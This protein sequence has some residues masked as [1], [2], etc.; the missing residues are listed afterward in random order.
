MPAPSIPPE[1]HNL[2][3]MFAHE[4]ETPLTAIKGYAQLLQRGRVE[5]RDEIASCSGIIVQQANRVIRTMQDTVLAVRI[6][7][8]L[9]PLVPT[10]L[11]VGAVISESVERVD[12]ADRGRMHFDVS[13]DVYVHADPRVV[14]T[15]VLHLLQS[16]VKYA[17]PSSRIGVGADPVDA[18]VRVWI[19]LEGAGA[20]AE[21]WQNALRRDSSADGD[22]APSGGLGFY[23]ARLLVEAHGRALA[24]RS[25]GGGGLE[26]TF[27]LPRYVGSARHVG[28]D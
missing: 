1:T 16:I 4:F 15:I 26:F 6:A 11:A 18:S 28:S 9:E 14:A 8:G 7:A 12:L 21:K 19:R 13:P 24:V 23:L 27:C 10:E 5:G 2:L 20:A 22:G 25:T 3:A 17:S